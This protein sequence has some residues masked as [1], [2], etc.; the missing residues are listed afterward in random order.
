MA[1]EQAYLDLNGLGT[2]W[3]SIK[4][5]LRDL[6]YPVGSYYETSDVDFDPNTEWGGTWVLEAAGQVH[7]SAGTGYTIGDTGGSKDAI[8]PSHNHTASGTAIA[9]HA[10]TKCTGAAVGD[11]AATKCTGGAVTN[12]AAFNTTSSGTCNIGSSGGHSHTFAEHNNSGTSSSYCVEVTSTSVKWKDLTVKGDGAHTHTVPNH[13]HGIPEHGHAF[14]QPSTPKFTHTV[15]QPSTPVL[16]HIVT[17][18]TISTEGADVTDANMPPYIV[19][20]RWH[21]TA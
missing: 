10:A 7:V 11:H 14:T 1:T 8:V 20:N 3:D 4:I 2:F 21:R 15:T 19:V 13:Q 9:D 5:G 18:P 6:Y 12:K 16:T 17:Q